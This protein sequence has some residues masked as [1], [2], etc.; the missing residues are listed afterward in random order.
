[1]KRIISYVA[2]NKEDGTNMG[3]IK[4]ISEPIDIE[5]ISFNSNNVDENSML[6]DCEVPKIIK[7]P[8]KHAI[9]SYNFD[10]N[11]IEV[12]Y[13]DVPYTEMSTQEK[14]E[15]LE[16]ERLKLQQENESLKQELS[17]ITN[18]LIEVDNKL[19]GGIDNE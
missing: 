12:D 13:E 11:I 17:L 16:T 7:L 4:S 14:L 8:G 18:V 2:Y 3:W 9:L 15:Y 1:M 5:D 19:S 10:S 6:V